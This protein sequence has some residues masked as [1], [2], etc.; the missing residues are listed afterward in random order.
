MGGAKMQLCVCVCP[1]SHIMCVKVK[2]KFYP[3]ISY[4]RVW[5]NQQQG[6]FPRWL[7]NGGWVGPRIILGALE[8]NQCLGVDGNWIPARPALSHF[9]VL[10]TWT[11]L[12][13]YMCVCVCVRARVCACVRVCVRARVCVCARV[14]A[15]VRVCARVCVRVCVCVRACVCACVYARACVR[16]CVCM[17]GCA[18]V[19]ARVCVRARVCVCACVCLC[20]CAC[21]CLCVCACV[22]VCPCSRGLVY[23][24][25]FYLLFAPSNGI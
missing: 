5:S 18:W 2:V 24:I 23:A 11:L 13:I 4:F 9:A 12:P 3:C 20:V 1:R 25:P 10:T 17:R 19:C 7:L 22:C 14:R 6:K 15:R 21:V 8:K 16:V